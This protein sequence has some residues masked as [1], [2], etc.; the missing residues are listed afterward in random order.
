MTEEKSTIEEVTFDP[1]DTQT[2][3]GSSNVDQLL[4]ARHEGD[5]KEHKTQ[6]D[7]I[8]QKIT[9]IEEQYKDIIQ[10]NNDN[11]KKDSKLKNTLWWIV[12]FAPFALLVFCSLGFYLSGGKDQVS[13]ALLYSIYG[14]GIG[15]IISYILTLIKTMNYDD[16]IKKIENKQEH[17]LNK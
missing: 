1:G 2:K 14:L 12:I 4:L 11:L 7:G 8:N 15:G 3:P 6:L 5:L 13:K 16:R 17:G 9:T 10:I